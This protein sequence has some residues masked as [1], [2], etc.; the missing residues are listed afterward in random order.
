MLQVLEGCTT[1]G[2]LADG[3]FRT[4]WADSGL[5]PWFV[6]GGGGLVAV[7]WDKIVR[8][9]VGPTDVRVFRLKTPSL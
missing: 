2:P 8:H 7:T 6:Y 9:E 5:G 3:S 1:V 4:V